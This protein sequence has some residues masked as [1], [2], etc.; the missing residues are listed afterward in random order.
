MDVWSFAETDIAKI[1]LKSTMQASNST[2][3]CMATYKT[4]VSKKKTRFNKN[5]TERF[6]SQ[7]PPPPFASW[8][9]PGIK[10]AAT[11]K[12]LRF[13]TLTRKQLPHGL[14]SQTWK[15]MAIIEETQFINTSA[16]T[17][18][19]NSGMDHHGSLL[20]D[21]LPSKVELQ[22]WWTL[23]PV[24]AMTIISTI[25]RDILCWVHLPAFYT[26]HLRSLSH[27]CC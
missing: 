22:V 5:W 18:P 15:S 16:M 4:I 21:A 12:F 19:Y 2:V 13:T 10:I 6:P 25:H 7:W 14:Q 8:K 3:K 11:V 24:I 9:D 26:R 17:N 20:D 23:W 1:F 27:H